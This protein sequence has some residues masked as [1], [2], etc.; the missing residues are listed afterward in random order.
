MSGALGIIWIG[1]GGVRERDGD[2][3][4]RDGEGMG[5]VGCEELV[6]FFSLLGWDWDRATVK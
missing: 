6:L 4:L 5:W 3:A 2:G 1:G